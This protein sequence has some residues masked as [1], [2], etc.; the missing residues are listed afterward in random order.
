MFKVLV[1]FSS[2][3]QEYRAI[4]TYLDFMNGSPVYLMHKMKGHKSRVFGHDN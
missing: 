2:A 1:L 4:G 3:I